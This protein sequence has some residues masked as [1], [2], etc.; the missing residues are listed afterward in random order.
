MRLS[1]RGIGFV[2]ALGAVF[3][4]S[5]AHGLR[6][7][8]AVAVP[9]VVVLGAAVWQVST[10]E[11]PELRRRI[12]TEGTVGEY[13]TVELSLSRSAAGQTVVRDRLPDGID[14]VDR[15]GSLTLPDWLPS[16]VATRLLDVSERF[17]SADA[18]IPGR[19]DAGD[20][21]LPAFAGSR[22]AYRVRLARRGEWHVGPSELVVR[23]VFGLVE[24]AFEVDTSATVLVYPTTH[25]LTPQA[26]DRLLA[27]TGVASG[28]D[29]VAFDELREYDT[30]DPLRD[31]HW[32]TSAKRGELFVAEYA[33]DT[34][35]DPVRIAAGADADSDDV[36][37]TATAT[38]A[39]ALL[40]SG[41]PVD[42]HTPDGRVEA[43]V[44]DTRSVLAALARVGPGRADAEA[45]VRID[46][47]EGRAT[48]SLD[49]H[50]LAFEEL[51]DGG[52]EY[53]EPT[54]SG[55]TEGIDDNND[56][57]H[58]NHEQTITDRRIAT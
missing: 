2:V 37:A 41:T 48:V 28:D 10:A 25:R 26:R 57:L 21:T 43:D 52:D 9:G 23:D 11:T 31:I 54:R 44:G 24:V 5:Q 38:I 50:R 49:G 51:V 35:E 17:L 46:A 36:M 20:I 32:R 18:S 3:V 55:S 22:V 47:R 42:I 4:L 45:T 8:G 14:A 19:N 56:V 29:R 1:W 53:P 34:G 30:G 7:L 6:S 33:G 27:L 40:E 15:S 13:A 39:L 12:R 58:A 16:P